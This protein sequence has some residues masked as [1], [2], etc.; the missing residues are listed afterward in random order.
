MFQTE[1]I[2]WLQA[3]GSPLLT[4]LLSLV[5]LLGYSPVYVVLL[6]ALGLGVRLR[7]GLAVMVAAVLAGVLVAGLK[8]WV[9]LPR[10]DEVDARVR[11]GLWGSGGTLVERGGAPD[12]WSRPS[13][14]AIAA[15]RARTPHN[16]GF[17]SGHV[18]GATVV[19][20][21]VA[22]FCRSRAAL[23][24][25]LFWV[26]TMAVSR[27]YL[28][29]H[30]LADVLGGLATG[31]V[32][33]ALAIPLV[34]GLEHA[35]FAS[36]DR[37]GFALVCLLAALLV[38]LARLV[39]LLP[40][41]YV[42]SLAGVLLGYAFL[43]LTGPPPEGGTTRQRLAR[44]ALALACYALGMAAFTRQMVEFPGFDP[45]RLAAGLVVTTAPI[46]V[47]IALARRLRLHG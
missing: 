15:V 17:P 23:L 34:R 7:P 8:A 36:R 47:P 26:P 46:V 1:P 40:S 42:G 20:L 4:S 37:R 45:G 18:A 14:Q 27:M 11:S 33:T 31:I 44:A 2:L 43:S 16:F 41:L 32:A 35:A 13:P 29:R 6:L 3:V 28:G 10:P 24:F 25:A 38:G 30:F 21:A 12:F 22:I 19:L 39:P 5:S 9:A